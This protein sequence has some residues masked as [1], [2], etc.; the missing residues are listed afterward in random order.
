MYEKV[1]AAQR[2]IQIFNG[3]FPFGNTVP[4]L[5]E[6]WVSKDE[7]ERE[8]KRKEEQQTRK[9]VNFLI[10]GSRDG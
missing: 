7:K 3:S 8:K 6:F 9:L 5:V 2:A 1:E 10:Y 4:L